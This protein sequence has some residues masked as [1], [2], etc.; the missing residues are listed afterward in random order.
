M[1][2]SCNISIFE[3]PLIL[4]L[5]CDSLT[6]QD[7]FA[8]LNVCRLW[9]TLF[10]LQLV[11]YVRFADLK[12][13]QTRLIINH[14]HRIQHL[15]ID[16]ADARWLLHPARCINLKT[17]SCVDFGYIPCRASC[18]HPSPEA[19]Q[20]QTCHVLASEDD[21]D[22]EPLLQRLERVDPTM[23]ALRLVQQN[24]GL[25]HLEFEHCRRHYGLSHF[26]PEVL[27]ALSTHRSLTR[28]KIILNY[29]HQDDS[30]ILFS[31]LKHLPDTLLDLEFCAHWELDRLNLELCAHWDLGRLNL[32]LSAEEQS[33]LYPVGIFRKTNRLRRLKLNGTE[34]GRV[35]PL[36]VLQLLRNAPQLS[37]LSLGYI[38]YDGERLLQD[39]VTACPSLKV[40]E[41]KNQTCLWTGQ[42]IRGSL[43]SLRTFYLKMRTR[44]PHEEVDTISGS[45]LVREQ[46]FRRFGSR[47]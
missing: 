5:I 8:C 40:L 46:V 25:T 30:Q 6:K 39:V 35:P 17:L 43:R 42:P 34:F 16:V 14:A 33:E 29:K 28:I 3:I 2:P 27:T 26:D 23:N 36:V 20:Y 7:L 31:V 24:P 47:Y 1:L 15:Q 12:A 41:L 10:Q 37:E 45:W 11:R 18:D 13:P 21:E 19:V 9:C 32:S 38:V 4:D 22:D 44:G